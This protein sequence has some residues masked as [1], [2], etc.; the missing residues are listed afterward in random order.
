MDANGNVFVTGKFEGSVTFGSTLLVSAGGTDVFV[1]KWDATAQSF[2]WATRGGGN[3]LDEGNSIAVQGTNVYVTGSYAGGPTTNVS[4]AGQTL[5]GS[6]SI[7]LFVAK[8]IDTS[9]G[10]TSAN[11]GFADGWVTSSQGTGEVRGRGIAVQHTGVF[12]T[13]SFT[14]N[15]SNTVIAGQALTGAGNYDLFVAKYIDTSTG[16][17]TATS[18]FANGWATSGGGTGGDI[19]TSIAVSGTD[20]YITGSFTGGSNARIAGQ[21]LGG[22]VVADRDMFVAKYVDTSTGNTTAT[23][24]FA[25]GWATSGGGDGDD[26]GNCIA[27]SGRGVFVTGEVGGRALTSTAFIAGRNLT[28]AGGFYPDMFL[29]KYVDTSTGNTTATSSFANGWATTGG[30]SNID[31]GC[32]LA[33]RGTAVFVTGGFTSGFNARFAG[34]ALG[35]GMN[36][37]LF[38]AKYIDTS[39]GNTTATSSFANGW[40]TSASSNSFVRGYA[41]TVSGQQLYVVG[42]TVRPATFG[43]FTVGTASSGSIGFLA[44]LT[45]PALP[46]ATQKITDVPFVLYPNPTTG[47]SCLLGTIPGAAVLVLDALGRTVATDTADATG[48]AKVP[49]GLAPGLYLVHSGGRV[50]RLMV[51]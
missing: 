5:S 14:S 25:N 35:T 29:A 18:S 6:S 34:Q 4:F 7:T 13:G 31:I 17:T 16:N 46:L 37:D 3:S 48:A 44:R 15:N 47:V 32:G 1:A 24:S 36:D 28:T 39:T 23:S 45:D 27:V 22:T 19:G 50:A 43:T 2:T 30:G 51:E 8:Y 49:G 33:V 40:A 21:A 10:H 20:V 9:T 41:L 26:Q 42:Y 38:V 12:V 11:S